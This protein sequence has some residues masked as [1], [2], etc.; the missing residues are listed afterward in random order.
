MRQSCFHSPR[1]GAQ[2]LEAEF[3]VLAEAAGEGVSWKVVEENC[4]AA[5][6]LPGVAPASSTSARTSRDTK[7]RVTGR[8]NGPPT[9]LASAELAKVLWG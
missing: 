5:G 2:G 6:S 4:V 1:G 9:A 3:P 8:N 7:L